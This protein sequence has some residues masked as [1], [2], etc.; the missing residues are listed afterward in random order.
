AAIV[1]PYAGTTRDM[2][3]I[4]MDLRGY[5]VSLIDTAGIGEAGGDLVEREGMRRA[6]EAA[7][8]ADLVLWVVD[9]RDFHVVAG[10]GIESQASQAA[11][12]I[13][14]NKTDLLNGGAR[15]RLEAK[16]AADNS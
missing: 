11:R 5:P 15:R 12:W 4:H 2:I 3:E 16:F 14:V 1:S 7:S 10:S 9:G 13:V 8:R 6:R